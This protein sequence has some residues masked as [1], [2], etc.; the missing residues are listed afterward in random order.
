MHNL[1]PHGGAQSVPRVNVIG[2]V[3]FLA[4]SDVTMLAQVPFGNTSASAFVLGSAALTL[5]SRVQERRSRSKLYWKWISPLSE[6][7]PQRSDALSKEF[8]RNIKEAVL[9]PYLT[10]FS[11]HLVVFEGFHHV[12][13]F[14]IISYGHTEFSL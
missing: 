13:G 8:P 1:V 9:P 12:L 5:I 10:S 7:Y 14:D 3:A 4:L 2:I 11:Q 6:E